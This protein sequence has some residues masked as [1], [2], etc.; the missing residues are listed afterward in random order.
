[1][2]AEDFKYTWIIP[3]EVWYV[4]VYLWVWD[5]SPTEI[6]FCKFFWGYAL[7]WLGVPIRLVAGL[8]RTINSVRLRAKESRRR[9]LKAKLAEKPAVIKAAKVPSIHYTLRPVVGR[10]A[11]FWVEDA[12]GDV[13]TWCIDGNVV[14]HRRLLKYFFETPGEHEV[15]LPN[16]YDEDGKTHDVKRVVDVRYRPSAAMRVLDGVSYGFT[17]IKMAASTAAH[18]VAHPPKPIAKVGRVS[19]MG[20]SVAS[21]VAVCVGCVV[22]GY[23]FVTHAGSIGR[24]F[25]HVTFPI[26]K[27]VGIVAGIAMV[28]GFLVYCVVVSGLVYAFTNVIAK[29]VAIGTK[30]G[31][32][33]FGQ[34]MRI[35]YVAVK[36]NTC[37]RLEIEGMERT[38]PDPKP[39]LAPGAYKRLDEEELVAD[40]TRTHA[41]ANTP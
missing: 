22:A 17:G 21:I 39:E 3:R 27:P 18:A 16:V 40:W 24:S 19:A 13:A 30:R 29:P 10:R 25:W 23:A 20:A 41:D 15:S 26:V 4:K 36:S 34:V 5:A 6:T 9:R 31:A 32:L 38:E 12:S 33:S 7:I 8:F 11:K 28:I 37:P 1:M 14:G 2:K 35:G